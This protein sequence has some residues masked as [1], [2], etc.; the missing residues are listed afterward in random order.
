MTFQEEQTGACFQKGPRAPLFSEREPH[1]GNYDALIT[2]NT[3]L[4]QRQHFK[5]D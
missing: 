3:G 4:G 5:K 2:Y 1:H